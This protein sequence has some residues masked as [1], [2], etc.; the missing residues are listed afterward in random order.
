MKMSFF[1]SL[2][3]RSKVIDFKPEIV[4]HFDTLSPRENK[5]LIINKISGD[6]PGDKSVSNFEVGW[7]WFENSL[8]P[9]IINKLMCF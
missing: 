2:G 7:K 8:S 1:L 5:I 4:C 6:K 3:S 9:L